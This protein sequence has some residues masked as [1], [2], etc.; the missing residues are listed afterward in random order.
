MKFEVYVYRCTGTCLDHSVTNFTVL[1]PPIVMRTRVGEREAAF[2]IS[3]PEYTIPIAFL[4]VTLNR[5]RNDPF[6]VCKHYADNR[7]LFIDQISNK[8]MVQEFFD[9]EENSSYTATFTAMFRAP[10]D[11]RMRSTT[12]A[13]AIPNASKVYLATLAFLNCPSCVCQLSAW[14]FQV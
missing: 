6:E 1:A 2:S 5:E 9:L 10:G 8:A 3:I 12:T 13:F 7:E 4:T 11:G 14:M